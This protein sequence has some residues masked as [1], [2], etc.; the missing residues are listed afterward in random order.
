ML[1]E[2][3]C[4]IVRPAKGFL[5]GDVL[6]DGNCNMVRALGLTELVLCSRHLLDE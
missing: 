5:A 6:P 4:N 2:S 3:V 1:H